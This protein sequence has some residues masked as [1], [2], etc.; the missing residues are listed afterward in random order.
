[1]VCVCSAGL[2][3]WL[4]MWAWQ[5]LCRCGEAW[6]WKP[7]G[8]LTLVLPDGVA[9]GRVRGRGRACEARVSSSDLRELR[10]CRDVLAGLVPVVSLDARL[11][12]DAVAAAAVLSVQAFAAGAR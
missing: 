6:G 7:L 8:V 4:A 5:Y 12:E 2:T 3:P 10:E 11:C 1:M 9:E